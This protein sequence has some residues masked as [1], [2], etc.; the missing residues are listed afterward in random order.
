MIELTAEQ[1]AA[2]RTAINEGAEAELAKFDKELDIVV[3]RLATEGWTLPSE[4]GIYAVKRLADSDEIKDV[5]A[6]LQWYYTEENYF[7]TEL[8]VKCIMDTNI[9]TGVKKLFEECWKAFKEGMYAICATSLMSVTEGI[10]SEFSEDK[11]DIRMMKVCQKM[12]D[13]FPTDGSTIQKHTWI[14]YNIFIRNLY[15]KRDFLSDEPDTINRHWLLHGRSD[16]E[17][18]ELDCI[19]LINAVQSICMI[20]R[21]EKCS[22][23]N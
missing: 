18:D 20:Y 6:F 22:E 12:V 13:T 8:M 3:N 19:R 21:V 11:R 16:F 10:L 7:H 9:K 4:L 23:V 17:I 15:E 2:I 5:N 1:L 14:S